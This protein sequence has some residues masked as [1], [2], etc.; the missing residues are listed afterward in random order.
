MNENY[1]QTLAEDA[2]Y[3]AQIDAKKHGPAVKVRSF[4][5]W[6]YDV[7]GNARDGFYVNDR[8]SH[9]TVEI[10]CK[11]Q[12]FNLDTPN[13][14]AT[15]EPTDRQLSRAAGFSRVSWDGS[16]GTFYAED[17][18]NGRPIGELCEAEA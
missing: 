7:W 18:R 4:R 6:T 10:A 13:E 11:R 17:S 12:I 14:F 8:Y 5:L 3:Q 1:A 15:W 16:D 9:G 2:A